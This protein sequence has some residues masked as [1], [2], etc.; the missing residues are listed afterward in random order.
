MCC[1]IQARLTAARSESST[2]LPSIKA[3][4]GVR[5]PMS[6]LLLPVWTMPFRRSQRA[7]PG[8]SASHGWISAMNRKWNVYYRTSTNGGSRWSGETVLSTYGAS[9]SYICT[10]CFRFP[11]GD[12]FDMDIDNQSH[13]QT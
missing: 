5:K 6:P 7:R 3:T 13:T 11:F 8:T 10:D 12:Y 4:R 9:Y 2:R 1:G